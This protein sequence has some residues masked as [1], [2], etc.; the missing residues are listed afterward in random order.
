MSHHIQHY[1]YHQLKAQPIQLQPLQH[2]QPSPSSLPSNPHF[3]QELQP[4]ITQ[5]HGTP[6]LQ[7]PT[8]SQIK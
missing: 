1:Q 8:Y 4:H 6:K 7:K 2:L 5:L 3:Y